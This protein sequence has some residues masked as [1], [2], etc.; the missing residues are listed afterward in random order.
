MNLYLFYTVTAIRM[1][2]CV[3]L[4]FSWQFRGQQCVGWTWKCWHRCSCCLL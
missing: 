4:V 2:I 3:T 1:S